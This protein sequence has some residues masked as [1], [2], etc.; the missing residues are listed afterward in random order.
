M[1]LLTSSKKVLPDPEE[2]LDASFFGPIQSYLSRHAQDHPDR[3]AISTNHKQYSYKYVDETSNRIANYLIRDGIKKG[4]VVA[5]FAHRSTAIV[6]AIMGVLKAGATF[7]VIDPAYPSERQIIYLEVSEPKGFI[8]LQKAG[9]LMPDVQTYINEKVR[10]IST[11]TALDPDNL[12]ALDKIPATNPKIEIGPN[13]IGTLSFTSGS[14]GRPKGVRG[15]HISYTHFYPWMKQEFHFSD[16]DHF[17]LLS[18]IAH[19]PIQRDSK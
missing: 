13:D 2:P 4:D 8:T 1:T 12:E 5:I 10:I 15:R 17:S 18:G 16:H 6:L 7:T 11:I 19:D 14:T 9:N 3:L